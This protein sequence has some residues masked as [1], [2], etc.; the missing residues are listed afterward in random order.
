MAGPK[1]IELFYYTLTGC[2]RHQTDR[3][4]YMSDTPLVTTLVGHADLANIRTHRRVVKT[5]VKINGVAD[6]NR[7]GECLRTHGHNVLQLNQQLTQPQRMYTLCV[8]CTLREIRTLTSFPT[9]ALNVLC[10]PI[11]PVRHIFHGAEGET[12]THFL[13]HTKNAF[14]RMNFDG[15]MEASF[16]LKPNSVGYKST[17]LIC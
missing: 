17:I 5:D 13:I 4:Q 6:R 3:D 10:I 11:P 9:Y 12:R 2:E 14:T 16:G 15:V 1:R 8:L 7:T